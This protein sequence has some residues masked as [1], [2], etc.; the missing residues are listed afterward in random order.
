MSNSLAYWANLSAIGA[1]AVTLVGAGVGIW[2]YV[3]YQRRRSR[4]AK[5]LVAYLKEAKRNA[6]KGK[7][8]QHTLIHLI[9][10]VRLSEQ[11]I[12]DLSFE[13]QNI[14]ITVGE[15]DQGRADALFFE[16]KP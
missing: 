10:H 6:P 16:Y 4:K 2:G 13:N 15:D 9:R 14:E 8:G 1:F 3:A 7:K 11:D 12:L 5:A